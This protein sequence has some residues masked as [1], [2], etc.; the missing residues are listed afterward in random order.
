ML[1]AKLLHIAAVDAPSS[2]WF[3]E[4][5]EELSKVVLAVS[6]ARAAIMLPNFCFVGFVLTGVSAGAT[7][8]LSSE[9]DFSALSSLVGSTATLTG[10]K[11]NL[12]GPKESA[13]AVELGR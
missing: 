7:S 3:A 2:A 8:E 13:L 4:M 11:G 6:S 1:S 12:V 10:P 9:S 5:I